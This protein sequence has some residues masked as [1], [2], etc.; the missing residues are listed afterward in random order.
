MR[1]YYGLPAIPTVAASNTEAN[2]NE[3]S[4][5]KGNSKDGGHHRPQNEQRDGVSLP[6]ELY[7]KTPLQKE[8]SKSVIKHSQWI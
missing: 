6:C 8:A 7:D 2:V 5:S 1:N 3:D 4:P